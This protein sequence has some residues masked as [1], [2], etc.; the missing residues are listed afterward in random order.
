MERPP[1]NCTEIRSSL[2]L[3]VGGDMDVHEL[4]SV[5]LHLDQCA[6]CR[7]QADRAQQARRVLGVLGEGRG[8][9]RSSSEGPDLW[10]GV[11]SQ[12][13]AEGLL[14]SGPRVVR[15]LVRPRWW[16]GGL[17]S[18]AAAAV[19]I[20]TQL[21]TPGP[22]TSGPATPDAGIEL[23][24]APGAGSGEVSTATAQPEAGGLVPV[25][26]TSE[27]AGAAQPAASGGL[28]RLRPGEPSL[29]EQSGRPGSSVQP[30]GAPN[31][32]GNALTGSRKLLRIR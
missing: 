32:A 21:R 31:D 14:E 12:L 10:G 9:K 6:D 27:L 28:R 11:R 13:I 4:E 24:A 15:P 5:A 2:P 16:V 1:V 26:A 30:V 18:A 19:L 23:V 3:Y 7:R 29:L 8:G 22:A 17:A 25:V 20:V